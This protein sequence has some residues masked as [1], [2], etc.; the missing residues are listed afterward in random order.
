MGRPGGFSVEMELDDGELLL[1]EVKNEKTA[2]YFLGPYYLRVGSMTGK[3]G[4][5]EERGGGLALLEQFVLGTL[6]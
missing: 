2:V 5:G 6:G 1:V 4:G 3:V